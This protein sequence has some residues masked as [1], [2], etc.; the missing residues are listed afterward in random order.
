MMVFKLCIAGRRNILGKENKEN[1]DA[2]MK[3]SSSEF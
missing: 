1:K 3:D 2:E